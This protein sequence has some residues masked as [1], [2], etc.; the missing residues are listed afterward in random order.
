M[1]IAHRPTGANVVEERTRN[2]KDCWGEPVWKYQVPRFIS[3][4]PNKV[5]SLRRAAVS[6]RD[7]FVSM[8]KDFGLARDRESARWAKDE[9]TDALKEYRAS[10][11]VLG[12]LLCEPPG[13]SQF[14]P[15]W[16][17][18]VELAPWIDRVLREGEA[19]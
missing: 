11:L 13:D 12:H 16:E 7:E 19:L 10:C 18:P 2:G 5:D 15:E 3:L 4:C 6:R 9:A 1:T 17:W 14:K 8:Q